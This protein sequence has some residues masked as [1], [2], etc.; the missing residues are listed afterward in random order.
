MVIGER[1][2]QLPQDA[3]K[4]KQ[5]NRKLQRPTDC[6]EANVKL[7][8]FRHERQDIRQGARTRTLPSPIATSGLTQSPNNWRSDKART[9]PPT[10]HATSGRAKNAQHGTYLQEY[11]GSPDM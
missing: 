1:R 3:A 2:K 10:A 4:N 8:S 6:P 7:G 5:R 11:V 9:N